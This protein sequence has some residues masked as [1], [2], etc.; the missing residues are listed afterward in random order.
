VGGAERDRALDA[1]DLPRRLAAAIDVV[2][3]ACRALPEVIEEAAWIGTRWRVR[4]RTFAHVLP[5]VDGAP[6]SYARAIGHDGP[7]VV[8]T[9]RAD[10]PEHDALEAMGWP[11]FT[12][13]WGRPIAGMAIDEHTD[14]DELAELVTESYCLLAPAKLAALVDRPQG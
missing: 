9:F 14:P 1:G 3:P 2:A 11:Y 13:S 10:G 4:G 8:V 7:V 12:A 6:A 5:I